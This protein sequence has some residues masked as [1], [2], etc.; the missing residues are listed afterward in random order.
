MKTAEL[1][2]EKF[3][4]LVPGVEAE[5]KLS[6]VQ[7]LVEEA[8]D[9]VPSTSQNEKILIKALIEVIQDLNTK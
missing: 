7:I 1:I 9:Y 8:N 4:Q 3:K 2:F 5:L 6:D